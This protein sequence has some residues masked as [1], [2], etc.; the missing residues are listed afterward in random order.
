MTAGCGNQDTCGR[1]RRNIWRCATPDHLLMSRGLCQALSMLGYYRLGLSQSFV[2]HAVFE[3]GE[4]RGVPSVGGA[5]EIAG[6]S[7]ELV[8]V[9]ASTIR[10]TLQ[11]L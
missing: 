9:V 7:L 11:V 10:T 8:Y 4:F 3:F 2:D 6:Y 1:S 5:N